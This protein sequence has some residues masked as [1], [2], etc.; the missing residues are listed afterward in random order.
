M[1][2]SSYRGRL[3]GRTCVG[4]PRTEL[5]HVFSP[6][7][8]LFRSLTSLMAAN[9]DFLAYLSYSRY[10]ILY[11]GVA[12]ATAAPCYSSSSAHNAIRL[13]SRSC[14]PRMMLILTRDW[15]NLHYIVLW[16]DRFSAFS[17]PMS[18]H[19]V[20][21][22]YRLLKSHFVLPGASCFCCSASLLALLFCTFLMITCNIL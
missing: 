18:G 2:A 3:Y 12:T 1:I 10:Y 14:T 11:F 7:A 21:L 19:F 17:N 13:P 15:S 22:I 16:R 8:L 9:V 6:P 20:S 5:H 4:K